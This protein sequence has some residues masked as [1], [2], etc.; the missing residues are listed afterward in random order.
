MVVGPAR[1][2]SGRALLANDPHLELTTPGPF[3]VVQLTV[4]GVFEA[5]GAA[6]PGLPALVSG[7]NARCAWGVTALGADVIDVYADTLSADGKRVKGPH[8]WGPVV[9][10]P[11]DLSFRLL[12]LSVPIP[13]QVRRYTPHGPVLVWDPKH[14]I[15]LAARWSAMEDERI[16]L[17]KLLGVERSTTAAEI[18]MRYR[19]LVTPG[20]NLVAADVSGDALYQACGLVPH[21]PSDP[22]PGVLPDDGR[23]E[24]PGFIAADSMPAWHLP[25]NGYAVNGNNLPQ[26]RTPD[27]WPRYDW[28]HDRAARMSQRLAGDPSV[29]LAD[30]ASV[31]NDTWSRASAR[32]MPALLA[33]LGDRAKSLDA[34]GRAALDALHAWDGYARRPDVGPTIARAWWNAYV[35]RDGLDGVPGLALAQL[36]GEAR[37]TLRAPSGAIE[38]AADAAA[39]ALTT[40]LDTLQAKLG[41][42]ASRWTWANA[43]RA[44]F[45][46]PI[47]RYL[48][49]AGWEPPL[50]PADGDGSTVCVGGSNAPWSFTYT[51]APA[52]RHVV[53][54]AD[55]ATSWVVIPPWNSA[56]AGARGADLRSRWASHGYVPLTMDWARVEREGVETLAR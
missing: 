56:E 5:A 52:F 31:Q 41:R 32:Q 23:H 18:A 38:S 40:A 50:T 9:T 6:V 12:G 46:H 36:T 11:F 48:N 15:A 8:G 44:R 54:L 1:S 20:I 45:S 43:H 28:A 22:G 14:R 42:D 51:H 27:A 37:D 17:A 19:S 16:T 35:R 24:W 7:R 49:Q 2:A 47:A 21:R 3:H 29:T 30:L 26:Q 53:D 13:G 4:P 33:A 25:P 34:R 39:G 55:T 10:R